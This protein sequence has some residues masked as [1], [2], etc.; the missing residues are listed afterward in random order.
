MVLPAISQRGLFA[1]LYPNFFILC[2]IFSLVCVGVRF[3]LPRTWDTALGAL[4]QSRWQLSIVSVLGL[5][6]LY[7][8]CLILRFPGYVDPV[9]PMVVAASFFSVHSKPVYDMVISYGPLCFLP[10]GL[11][12]KLFGATVAVLKGVVGLAN[13]VFILVLFVIFKKLFRWPSSLL[14]TIL[15]LSTCLMKQNYLFQARGDLFIYVAV[16]LSLLAAISEGGA[17]GCVLMIAAVTLGC[18]VKVTAFM[19]F[20]YPLSLFWQRH[21][22]RLLLLVA[23][24]SILLSFLPFA[25]HTLNLHDYLHWLTVMSH[26]PKSIREFL[27]NVVITGLLLFPCLLAYWQ[28]H[29]RHHS[30]ARQFLRENWIPFSFMTGSILAMDVLASKIGAGRHHL[31]PY[32]VFTGYIVAQLIHKSRSGM[33]SSS[34]PGLLHVYLCGCLALLLL[35]TEVSELQDVRTL[36]RQE[37]AQS[38]ALENDVNRVLASY[39]GHRVE[40]GNGIGEF[41]LE[42]EYSPMFS[43]P[44]LIFAG[45]SYTFDPSAQADIEMVNEPMRE[46]DLRHVASCESDVWLIPRGQVPFHSVSIYSGMYPDRYSGRL[47]FPATFERMFLDTYSLTSSSH[48]FDIYT[49]KRPR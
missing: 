39:S 43:A 40:L 2:F 48:Y 3:L 28:L 30:L 7:I 20:V 14:A 27:G 37:A 34:S 46:S 23:A 45:G 11:A 47:L 38:V 41:D 16:A 44:Q 6:Y 12:M 5:L 4:T 35:L 15:V 33:P 42:R 8:G 24:G 18:G 1:L 25:L 19:Y 10:Y 26:Q 31:V 17:L 36:T 22:S 9:E 49:C 32:F 29:R 13:A 21:G